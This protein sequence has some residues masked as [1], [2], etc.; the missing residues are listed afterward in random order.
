MPWAVVFGDGPA[1]RA[2][3][4]EAAP[5]VAAERGGAGVGVAG[6][7]ADVDVVGAGDDAAEPC[8]VGRWR[9]SRSAAPVTRR[10]HATMT[11]SFSRPGGMRMAGLR[12]YPCP[13]WVALGRWESKG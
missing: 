6:A 12:D 8:G 10:T 7:T 11:A 13:R 5:G 4:G 3:D 1:L 2:G 9:A